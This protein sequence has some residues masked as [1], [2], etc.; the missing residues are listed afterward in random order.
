MLE[1]TLISGILMDIKDMGSE[2]SDIKSEADVSDDEISDTAEA[3]HCHR[4]CCWLVWWCSVSFWS[5]IVH[6]VG[7][8]ILVTSQLSHVTKVMRWSLDM[9]SMVNTCWTSWKMHFV[10]IFQ[11][12][13][14]WSIHS[15]HF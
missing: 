8:G 5:I 9:L 7:V 1:E 10:V 15:S 6:I 4:H 3:I 2:T 11:M 14:F 12:F 13:A